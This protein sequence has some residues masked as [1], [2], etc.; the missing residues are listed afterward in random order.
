M[1]IAWG[2]KVS[3]QFKQ[4]VLV[5]SESLGIDPN[6]LMAC[7]AFETGCTFSPSIRNKWTGATG[8]IQFMP[9]TARVMKT[10][11]EALS[12]MTAEDQ[13]E[14]VW[15]Y[16]G[17]IDKSLNSL[18][19]V[20]MAILWPSAIGK[21][22]DYPIFSINHTAYKPNKGLDHDH[23]GSVTKAEACARVRELLKEGLKE[24]NVG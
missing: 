6:W 19:D 15:R 13:L 16:F 7:M 12:R 17:L 2:S 1:E 14:Y 9:S 21:P 18:E 10:S 8:L 4:K 5:D 24:G 20:Y 22:N 11:V 23:D 3:P